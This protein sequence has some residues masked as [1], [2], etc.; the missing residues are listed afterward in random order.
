MNERT[1]CAPLPASLCCPG[2]GESCLVVAGLEQRCGQGLD[3]SWW[4]FQG[5]WLLGT[6]RDT[7][8]GVVVVKIAG[9]LGGHFPAEVGM[10]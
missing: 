5:P 7:G 9:A 4:H 1:P 10:W 3:L 8:G 6:Q 2:A